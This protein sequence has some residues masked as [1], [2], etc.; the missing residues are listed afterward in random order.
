MKPQSTARSG[1]EAPAAFQKMSK[2]LVEAGIPDP[3]SP[4][5]IAGFVAG[6]ICGLGP[7]PELAFDTEEDPE[8]I[9]A[10]DCLDELSRRVEEHDA[11]VPAEDLLDGVD[12]KNL[13]AQMVALVAATEAQ[14]S[15]QAGH[16]ELA[17]AE[18]AAATQN[19]AMADVP[20]ARAYARGLLRGLVMS[21]E[22]EE[23]LSG[24]AYG[25]P[26]S[27]IFILTEDDLGAD[28]GS[29]A[30]VAEARQA[31]ATALPG[32]VAQLWTLSHNEEDGE[33]D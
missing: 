16:P 7:A 12:G 1:A 9:L 29:A 19:P 6:L 4:W 30:E 13:V 3:M 5:Q 22:D 14:L 33:E 31:V 26:L 23:T 20:A 21:A 32:L 28:F 18:A 27:L 24:E 10:L 2:S 25:E 11:P 15:Q 17:F 8:Q